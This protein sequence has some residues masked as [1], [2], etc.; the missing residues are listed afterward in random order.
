MPGTVSDTG[1]V[2]VN[3][4][5]RAPALALP[6]VRGTNKKISK[7]HSGLEGNKL[8]RGI[9]NAERREVCLKQRG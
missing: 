5:G 8:R 2:A 7:L 9:R 3:K 4:M 1:D 6:L